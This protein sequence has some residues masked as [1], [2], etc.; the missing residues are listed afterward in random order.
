M[1]TP[2]ERSK[3]AAVLYEYA[4]LHQQHHSLFTFLRHFS[5]R[6]LS[7]SVAAVAI[8]RGALYWFSPRPTPD[9][10]EHVISTVSPFMSG[11]RSLCDAAPRRPSALGSLFDGV[12]DRTTAIDYS[13]T[14]LWTITISF[15][16]KFWAVAT[17]SSWQLQLMILGTPSWAIS[18]TT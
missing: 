6:F 13:A 9:I 15:V 5:S 17:F 10:K 7:Y 14:Y 12:V 16:S 2:S 4:L 11:G 1:Q 18:G 3:L 8:I